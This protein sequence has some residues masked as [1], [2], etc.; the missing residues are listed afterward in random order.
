MSRYRCTN[1]VCKGASWQGEEPVCPECKLD[2]R[3]PRFT[4]FVKVVKTVH[5]DPPSPVPGV[6]KGY[7]ACDPETAIFGDR[8]T[9]ATGDSTV[10]NCAACRASLAFTEHAA[11]QTVP[12]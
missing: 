9:A 11:L 3:L 7:F 4:R 2:G 6:G 5:W 1:P 12:A 10:V 8:E